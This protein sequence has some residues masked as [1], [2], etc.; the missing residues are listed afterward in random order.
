MMLTPFMDSK[1][2]VIFDLN[3]FRN[4]MIVDCGV[5]IRV[6]NRSYWCVSA[7]ITSI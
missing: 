7:F 4:C 1:R 6:L 5:E 3:C 2:L